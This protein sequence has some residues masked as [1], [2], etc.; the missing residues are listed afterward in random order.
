MFEKMHPARHIKN[1][2]NCGKDK[3]SA[4]YYSPAEHFAL[5]EIIVLFEGAIYFETIPKKHKQ[6]GIKSCVS[7]RY[8]GICPV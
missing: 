5:D 7:L 6:F 4:K 2:S 8:L 3:L 1:T